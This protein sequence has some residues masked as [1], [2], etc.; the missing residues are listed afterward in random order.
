MAEEFIPCEQVYHPDLIYLQI[1]WKLNVSPT[2][3]GTTL[4]VDRLCDPIRAQIL[5]NNKSRT[6]YLNMQQQRRG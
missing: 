6:T 3:T 2:E 5:Y 4:L 1:I